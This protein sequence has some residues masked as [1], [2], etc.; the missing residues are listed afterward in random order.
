M[1][2][3]LPMATSSSP[4][5]TEANASSDEGCKCCGMVEVEEDSILLGCFDDWKLCLV[6][7][8]LLLLDKSKVLCLEEESMLLFLEESSILLLCLGLFSFLDLG[9]IRFDFRF[10]RAAGDEDRDF[11]EV[12]LVLV[13][14]ARAGDVSVFSSSCMSS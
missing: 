6:E 5:Q 2:V 1:G 4:L 9:E 3:R 10:A 11:G 8:M 7:S 14:V 13:G 12:V